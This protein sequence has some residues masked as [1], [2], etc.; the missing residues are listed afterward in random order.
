M[1]HGPLRPPPAKL[2]AAIKQMTSLEGLWGGDTDYST[3][4]RPFPELE[5]S[6]HGQQRPARPFPELGASRHGQQ[7]SA[8]PPMAAGRAPPAGRPSPSY[9]SRH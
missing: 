4:A 3:P 2:S 8:R 9:Q 6:R 5:A 7:R 1:A